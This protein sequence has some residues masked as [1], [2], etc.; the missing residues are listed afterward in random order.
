MDLK[1]KIDFFSSLDDERQYALIDMA[2]NLGVNGLLMFR[3][4]LRNMR[5]KQ[6]ERSAQECL[7]SEY[8][9]CVGKRALRIAETIK[10]G[11]FKI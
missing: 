8:A 2:F 3:K 4:M 1:K 5:N 11:V 10:T 7:N 6:Y 9:K